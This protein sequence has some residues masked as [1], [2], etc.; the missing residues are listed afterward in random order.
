MELTATPGPQVIRSGDQG[1]MPMG[2]SGR[3]RL[4]VFTTHP[5]GAGYALLEASHPAGLPRIADHIHL[6]H[7][8]TFVVLE[9]EYDVRLGDEILLA[10]AGDYV[11]IPR[12][13][14]HTL[15]NATSTTARIMTVM[16]PADGAGLIAELGALAGAPIEPDLLA[17]IHARHGA[18][19]VAPLPAW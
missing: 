8:E 19:L 18:V 3:G 6:R 1:G 14:T 9:G 4:K 13:T 15:R 12:G 10:R 7:D 11:F 17:E 2:T 5:G 16:G